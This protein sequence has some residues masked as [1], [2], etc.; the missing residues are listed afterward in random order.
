ME[1]TIIINLM[2]AIIKTNLIK[3]FG[4]RINLT[5]L[6]ITII[7]EIE[8]FFYSFSSSIRRF[9][10]FSGFRNIDIP[11]LAYNW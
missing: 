9:I 11:Q 5:G 6:I 1:V 8:F 4:E 2:E 10:R 3:F 7:K